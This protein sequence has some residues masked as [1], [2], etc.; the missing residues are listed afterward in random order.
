[1]VNPNIYGW[2][3]KVDPFMMYQHY[4]KLHKVKLGVKN[5]VPRTHV[6]YNPFSMM[7]YTN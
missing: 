6:V 3:D 7:R 1:M 2:N 5:R 4:V